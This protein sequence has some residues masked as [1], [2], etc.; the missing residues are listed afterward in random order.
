MGEDMRPLWDQWGN[1]RPLPHQVVKATTAAC[2]IRTRQKTWYRGRQERR[3]KDLT[4]RL[5]ERRERELGT[6]SCAPA[7]RE[8]LPSPPG[9]EWLQRCSEI[10]SITRLSWMRILHVSQSM[11]EISREYFI[12]LNEWRKYI[13]SKSWCYLH[14]LH[15]SPY[16]HEINFLYT[17]NCCINICFSKTY[18]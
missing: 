5:Y 13:Y 2:G 7:T 17:D 10:Y 16:D 3:L 6:P 8:E 9:R 12:C 15:C 1:T 11:K 14:R 4:G 18:L